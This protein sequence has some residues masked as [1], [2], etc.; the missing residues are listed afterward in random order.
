MSIIIGDPKFF[1]GI[2]ENKPQLPAGFQFIEAE[3]C[4]LLAESPTGQQ[5]IVSTDAL[6]PW[7]QLS[8]GP[9]KGG[10]YMDSRAGVIKL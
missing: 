2:I 9:R 1:H 5:Y 4:W 6:F 10:N 8:S 3:G 7:R